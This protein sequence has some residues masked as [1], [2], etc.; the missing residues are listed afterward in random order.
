VVDTANAELHKIAPTSEQ[1]GTN[2][3]YKPC[4]FLCIIGLFV[5]LFLLCNK[6]YVYTRYVHYCL[7]FPNGFSYSMLGLLS[8]FYCRPNNPLSSVLSSYIEKYTWFFCG[9]MSSNTNVLGNL[10]LFSNTAFSVYWRFI[11]NEDAEMLSCIYWQDS[12]SPLGSVI[13]I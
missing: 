10:N 2:N 1:Q 13:W 8:I 5:T 4:R 3:M 11:F 7:I 6:K 9:C 12:C